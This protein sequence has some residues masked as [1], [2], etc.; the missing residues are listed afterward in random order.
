[1]IASDE[2]GKLC[3]CLKQSDLISVKKQREMLG[4]ICT[5]KRKTCWCFP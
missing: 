5:K 3:Y 2:R 4:E 1:M